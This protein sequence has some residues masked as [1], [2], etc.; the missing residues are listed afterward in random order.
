M[1]KLLLIIF[2]LSI[3]PV[4]SADNTDIDQ[5]PSL[6]VLYEKFQQTCKQCAKAVK[7][8]RWDER[9]I[10][11]C[12]KSLVALSNFRSTLREKNKANKQVGIPIIEDPTVNDQHLKQVAHNLEKIQESMQRQTDITDINDILPQGLRE[13]CNNKGVCKSSCRDIQSILHAVITEDSPFMKA[14]EECWED[15]KKLV[16]EAIKRIGYENN[17]SEQTIHQQ[18]FLVKLLYEGESL[19][20]DEPITL[21]QEVRNKKELNQKLP[22][23]LCNICMDVLH[24]QS[25]GDSSQRKQRKQLEQMEDYCKIV[26]EHQHA[27]LY[28]DSCF[29]TYYK[30]FRSGLI[31]A[32]LELTKYCVEGATYYVSEQTIH[33]LLLHIQKGTGQ[34][35]KIDAE[36]EALNKQKLNQQMPSILCEIC[37]N[38]PQANTNEDYKCRTLREHLYAKQHPDFEKNWHSDW[39]HCDCTEEKNNCVTACLYQRHIAGIKY[40]NEQLS[41]Q[42]GFEQAV[43]FKNILDNAKEE[44]SE[45]HSDKGKPLDQNQE[46]ANKTKLNAA[47]P[48][49]M[50]AL[51][52]KN[53]EHSFCQNCQTYLYNL[54]YFY[55]YPRWRDPK[56]FSYD[57][58]KFEK[59]MQDHNL[60]EEEK[61][62]L[63]IELREFRKTL[64]DDGSGAGLFEKEIDVLARKLL[65]VEHKPFLERRCYC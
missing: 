42:T 2:L 30:E 46:L 8:N 29:V 7:E 45:Q 15:R 40:N 50:K 62:G 48:P 26:R 60:S 18:I 3:F 43:L 9:H 10:A 33:Q 17:W 58:S 23:P 34:D 36:Q 65:G 64:K 25:N 4:Q 44:Q 12:T 47:L 16:T 20:Q 37:N 6:K 35:F 31:K 41:P 21:E 56:P 5:D 1:N 53:L 51:C 49:K 11:P 28:S 59:F 57:E 61:R 52:N 54:L 27:A 19:T 38:N 32:L 63:R 55:G 14:R 39:Q 13:V 22:Q 24:K